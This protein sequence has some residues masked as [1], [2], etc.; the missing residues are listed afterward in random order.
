MPDLKH[1]ILLFCITCSFKARI[2]NEE[3]HR[4]S[5]IKWEDHLI[6]EISMFVGQKSQE[7]IFDLDL[8]FHELI[9]P[10]TFQPPDDRDQNL[11]DCHCINC[12]V[13]IENEDSQFDF[14]HR[15]FWMKKTKVIFN[16]MKFDTMQ[17]SGLLTPKVI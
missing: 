8:N 12:C 14:R 15:F 4:L 9:V 3:I 17:T 11:L 16:T 5:L 13:T 1:L 6:T 7:I 10:V 2:E